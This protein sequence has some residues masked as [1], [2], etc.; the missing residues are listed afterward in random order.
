MMI[1]QLEN[2]VDHL[3]RAADLCRTSLGDTGSVNALILLEHIRT[4]GTVRIDLINF[5]N[6][7]K[8]DEADKCK[9]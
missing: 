5:M 9:K 1:N 7:L 3:E 8:Q 4:I 6:A 2:A